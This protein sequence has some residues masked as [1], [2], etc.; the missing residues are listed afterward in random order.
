[1]ITIPKNIP[2]S[3]ALI[4]MNLTEPSRPSESP[5]APLVSRT[6]GAEADALGVLEARLPATAVKVVVNDGLVLTSSTAL[7]VGTVLITVVLA[8]VVAIVVVEQS[9]QEVHDVHSSSQSL[10][11][12]VP[13]DVQPGQFDPGHLSSGHEPEPHGPAVPVGQGPLSYQ[14]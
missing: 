2:R 9:V 12:H 3:V 8:G 11:S 13:L 5:I 6:G 1:M 4:A 14:V 7:V 10:L